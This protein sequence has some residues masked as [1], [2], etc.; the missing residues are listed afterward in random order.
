VWLQELHRPSSHTGNVP[1]PRS[2][3]VFAAVNGL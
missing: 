2:R 1:V 3:A